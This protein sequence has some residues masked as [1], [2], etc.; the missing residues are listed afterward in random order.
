MVMVFREN[1]SVLLV[2]WVSWNSLKWNVLCIILWR[3]H[4]KLKSNL[5]SNKNEKNKEITS[6]K[7]IDENTKEVLEDEKDKK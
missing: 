7:N 1:N 3:K 2:K 5:K 4:F 6:A